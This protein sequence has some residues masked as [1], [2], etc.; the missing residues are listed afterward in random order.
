[1]ATSST[2]D[3]VEGMSKVNYI[4]KLRLDSRVYIT[5]CMVKESETLGQLS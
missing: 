1:M 4:S 5:N 2:K 3:H